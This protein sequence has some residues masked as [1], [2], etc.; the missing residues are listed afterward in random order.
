VEDALGTV[1]QVMD[2]FLNISGFLSLATDNAKDP[3]LSKVNGDSEMMPLYI[4]GTAVGL[5]N[6][7]LTRVM[8]T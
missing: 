7:F 5:S 4:A 6:E 8:G 1:S 3:N 2:A